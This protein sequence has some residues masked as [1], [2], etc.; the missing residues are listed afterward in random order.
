MSTHNVAECSVDFTLQV[1]GT[2]VKQL[3]DQQAQGQ[4]SEQPH[5]AHPLR[6]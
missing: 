1:C 6:G 4:S 2:S 3:A 5:G